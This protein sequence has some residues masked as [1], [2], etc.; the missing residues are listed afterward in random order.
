MLLGLMQHCEGLGFSV[1]RPDGLL[2]QILTLPYLTLPYLTLP[3]CTLTS[4]CSICLPLRFV[5]LGLC[6]R[7]CKVLGCGIVVFQDSVLSRFRLQHSRSLQ[8]LQPVSTSRYMIQEDHV[9]GFVF[10]FALLSHDYCCFNNTHG[11][12]RDRDQL[13]NTHHCRTCNALTHD[14]YMIQKDHVYSF[15]FRFALLSHDYCCFNNTHGTDRDRDQLLNTHHC[16]TCN[17]LRA[18][19]LT[20]RRRA[21]GNRNS[22]VRSSDLVLPGLRIQLR[23]HFRRE[24]NF[25]LTR[26]A[27][28]AVVVQQSEDSGSLDG[29]MQEYSL[30]KSQVKHDGARSSLGSNTKPNSKHWFTASFLQPLP[31]LVTLQDP[32]NCQLTSSFLLVLKQQ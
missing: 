10:R 27:V 17:A 5:F 2:C 30:S 11:T 8:N 1:V 25:T 7:C 16:R 21:L 24:I 3:S 4:A 14:R 15:V 19:S 20:G 26:A 23:L 6:I 22:L 13:L 9:Y 28:R 29:T 12:D 32:E 18:Q 31:Y